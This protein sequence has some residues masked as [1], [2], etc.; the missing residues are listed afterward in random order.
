MNPIIKHG[1]SY[2]NLDTFDVFVKYFYTNKNKESLNKRTQVELEDVHK[3]CARRKDG[4]I[5]QFTDKFKSGDEAK[6]W[7][8][9]LINTYL[10]PYYNSKLY[11]PDEPGYQHA[12]THFETQN[13]PA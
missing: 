13:L 10:I 12:K 6:L 2:Y 7:L 5:F 1:N 3:V 11:A 4:S 9:E 8:D